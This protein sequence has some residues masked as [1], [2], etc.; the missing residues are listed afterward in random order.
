MK[1]DEKKID[2]R[3][4]KTVS[5]DEICKKVHRRISEKVPNLSVRDIKELLYV[6]MALTRAVIQA[7][8][9][10]SMRIKYLGSFLVYGNIIFRYMAKCY[11][12]LLNKKI[13][14]EEYE[15]ICKEVEPKFTE[16]K[17]YKKTKPYDFNRKDWEKYG[18]FKK[19]S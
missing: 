6:H 5:L 3:Y 2:N 18:S 12:N 11:K 15:D 17:N 7:P 1:F 19:E 9:F 14:K 10:K 13:T 16:L 4:Y 8:N